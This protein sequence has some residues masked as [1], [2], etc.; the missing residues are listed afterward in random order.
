MVNAIFSS[1]F[2][3]ASMFDWFHPPNFSPKL[4]EAVPL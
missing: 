3:F 2:A 4:L 1:S